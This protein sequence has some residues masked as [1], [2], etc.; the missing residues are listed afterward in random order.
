VSPG[1]V[2]GSLSTGFVCWTVEAR[3]FVKFP[4]SGLDGIFLKD[5]CTVGALAKGLRGVE[6]WLR[7]V[8]GREL[9]GFNSG[10]KVNEVCL[11]FLDDTRDQ[12]SGN[13]EGTAEAFA[14][15]L[16]GDI[17]CQKVRLG[18]VGVAAEGVA[19]ELAGRGIDEGLDKLG[20]TVLA[21][22]FLKVCGINPRREEDSGWFGVED[23]DELNGKG[24][25][26]LE[27]GVVGIFAERPET[28]PGASSELNCAAE[29]EPCSWSS[30]ESSSSS[31]SSFSPRSSS[32]S[33][34]LEVLGS[35]CVLTPEE[36]SRKD[37]SSM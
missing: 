35:N 5:K 24:A 13:D 29:T 12:E 19:G 23:W 30:S 1:D 32:S 15:I 2:G 34:A 28:S 4:P 27:K 21:I 9:Q 18:G 26:E 11:G 8:A 33:F 14:G 7:S 16:E 25:A 3:V 36:L 31:S 17:S 10:D 20:C 6:A 22:R 37:G